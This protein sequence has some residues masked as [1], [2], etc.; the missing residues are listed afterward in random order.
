MP[1]RSSGCWATPS[2]PRQDDGRP[3]GRLLLG[4]L[5]TTAALRLA[6]AVA[7]FVRAYPEVDLTLRTGTSAELL[8]MVRAGAVEGAFVCGPVADPAL[9]AETVL[10]EELA[11]LSAP[12][13]LT[14]AEAVAAPALRI[15]VLRSGCSYRQIL[16]NWL[17]RQGVTAPRVMEFGTLEAVVAS[18]SA[19]L[20]VTMLPRALLGPVWRQGRVAVHA[21]AGSR[22]AGR[23]AVR[24]PP[25]RVRLRRP[26]RLPVPAQGHAAGR[27]LR[28][29]THHGTV[30]EVI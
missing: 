17:V 15:V 16:E 25:R 20:G 7:A 9:L 10:E 24:P 28:R 30:M 27:P 19:G 2:A 21:P 22:G 11:L 14:L 12:H 18:V 26:I 8:E 23:D 5:E 4:T 29:L 1:A 6:D 13:L 3:R